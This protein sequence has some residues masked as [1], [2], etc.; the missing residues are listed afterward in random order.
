MATSTRTTDQC[1][2]ANKELIS[3]LIDMFPKLSFKARYQVRVL[4][5]GEKGES[6][7]GSDEGE[8]RT[9]HSSIHLVE[10][11]LKYLTNFFQMKNAYNFMRISKDTGRLIFLVAMAMASFLEEFKHRA[12]MGAENWELEKFMV[13]AGLLVEGETTR[14]SIIYDSVLYMTAEQFHEL[15]DGKPSEIISKA[16]R[17]YVDE[18][19][20]SADE[21][22][23]VV[24]N[25]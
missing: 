8:L 5:G 6:E 4:K 17:A 22:G 3:D 18:G 14:N 12:S 11:S 10:E 13:S 1:E 16:G 7:V 19:E 23:A 15:N 24:Y 20:E 25:L 2:S 9:L 21:F